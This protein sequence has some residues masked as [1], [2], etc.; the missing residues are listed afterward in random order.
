M[1]ADAL[2]LPWLMSFTASCT[3]F[4]SGKMMRGCLLSRMISCSFSIPVA[5]A[6]ASSSHEC[7]LLHLSSSFAECIL[8]TFFS[9]FF[10]A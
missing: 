5:K 8:T 3:G 6:N 4:E 9:P 7:H 2:N 10:T 1:L